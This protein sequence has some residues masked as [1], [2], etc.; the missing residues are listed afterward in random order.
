MVVVYIHTLWLCINT[1]V[2]IC[3]SNNRKYAKEWT[4]KPPLLNFVVQVCSVVVV[5]VY[6][7]HATY[8]YILIKHITTINLMGFYRY[9]D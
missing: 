9:I 4:V 2:I 3:N 6:F 1:L 5:V 8:T 7:G